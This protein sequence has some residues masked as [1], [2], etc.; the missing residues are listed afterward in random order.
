ML[1]KWL[2]SLVMTSV[3]PVNRLLEFGISGT[4]P[5]D[6]ALLPLLIC[7]RSSAVSLR[8]RVSNCSTHSVEGA[9]ANG[10]VMSIWKKVCSAHFEWSKATVMVQDEGGKERGM[11]GGQ[12]TPNYATR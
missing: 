2:L 8:G 11:L 9:A 1:E 12:K 5:S 7:K 4:I 3:R 6:V 10:N